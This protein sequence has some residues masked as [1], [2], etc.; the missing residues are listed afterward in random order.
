MTL[1]RF[2]KVQPSAEQIA[3]DLRDKVL[4]VF[5]GS[6][7]STDELYGKVKKLVRFGFNLHH[8]NVILPWNGDDYFVMVRT[9]YQYSVQRAK[10]RAITAIWFNEGGLNE[11]KEI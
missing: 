3:S 6:T 8:E 7:S 11:M 10:L 5:A 1:A 4:V 9:S 2:Y